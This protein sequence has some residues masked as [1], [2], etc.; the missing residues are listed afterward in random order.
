MPER[1]DKSK[2]EIINKEG[3]VFTRTIERAPNNG[4]LEQDEEY[5]LI[6]VTSYRETPGDSSKTG[7]ITTY[8]IRRGEGIFFDNDGQINMYDMSQVDLDELEGIHELV[9][10]EKVAGFY[11][12]PGTET[13]TTVFSKKASVEGGILD[14]DE[15]SVST[16]IEDKNPHSNLVVRFKASYARNFDELNELMSS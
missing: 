1:I 8:I 9:R 15:P 7:T 10:E 16:T 14:K 13:M 6:S 2:S 11:L 3:R 5:G 12:Y 4:E